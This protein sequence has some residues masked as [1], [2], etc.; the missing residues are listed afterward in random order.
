MMSGMASGFYGGNAYIDLV[1]SQNQN[2][3]RSQAT[4]QSTVSNSETYQSD[5]GGLFNIYEQV[6]TSAVDNPSELYGYKRLNVN[7]SGNIVSESFERP[8]GVHPVSGLPYMAAECGLGHTSPPEIACGCGIYAWREAPEKDDDWHIKNT[9]T[10]KVR[11]WGKV[12]E[13]RKPDGY[14]AQY[15]EIVEVVRPETNLESAL[16][17]QIIEQRVPRSGWGNISKWL[18]LGKRA[19]VI[20]NPITIFCMVIAWSILYALIGFMFRKT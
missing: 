2:R 6:D 20:I 15:A 14:R 3:I 19:A 13:H 16:L 10:V 18:R 9:V 17:A 1:V 12:I 5:D 4:R 7:A 8:W 11:L